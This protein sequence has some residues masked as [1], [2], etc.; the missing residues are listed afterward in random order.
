MSPKPNQAKSN[1]APKAPRNSK[2]LD[3]FQACSV[4]IRTMKAC[5]KRVP[6]AERAALA[7]L[8]GTALGAEPEKLRSFMS[9]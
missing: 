1:G 9:A 2:A 3:A 8:L 7:N 5:V 6:E 4:V